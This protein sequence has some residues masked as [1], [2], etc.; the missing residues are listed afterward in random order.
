MCGERDAIFIVHAHSLLDHAPADPY[1]AG[2]DH[3][4]FAID[5]AGGGG[6]GGTHFMTMTAVVV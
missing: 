4:G 6:G 3:V 2:T 1:N 5:Q